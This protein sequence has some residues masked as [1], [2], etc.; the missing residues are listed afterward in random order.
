MD[1]ADHAVVSD[2]HDGLLIHWDADGQRRRSMQVCKRDVC[3]IQAG[4]LVD[5]ETEASVLCLGN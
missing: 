5:D 2:K 4:V 1:L 3:E